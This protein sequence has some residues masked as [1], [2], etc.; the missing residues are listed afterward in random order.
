MRITK[1]NI[2][3][4][5]SKFRKEAEKVVCRNEVYDSSN[6]SPGKLTELLHELQVYQVE[7]EMQNEE[8]RISQV[9]LEK[10]RLK[11]KNLFNSAPAGFFVLDA[12]GIVQELNEKGLLML[13]ANKSEIINRRIQN[14]ISKD[15][16]EKFVCFFKRI[17]DF[18][19]NQSGEFKMVTANGRNFYTQMEGRAVT[20]EISQSAAFYFTIIDVTEKKIAE[21]KQN[22]TRKRLELALYASSSGTWNVY[23]KTGKVLLDQHS[24]SI[25]RLKEG[26]LIGNYYSFLNIIHPDDRDEVDKNIHAAIATETEL[27]VTFRLSN[28]GSKVYYIEAMGQ[29]IKEPNG[30]NDFAGLLTD[31]TEKKTLEHVALKLKFNE[32]NRI[33]KTILETQENERRRI[34]NDLHHSV[35]Q[36]LYVTKLKFEESMHGNNVS[37]AFLATSILIDEAI[38]EVRNIS[39]QLS[40]S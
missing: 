9:E 7:V 21:N 23:L 36:L 18:N 24:K 4:D 35:G 32:Q 26:G 3:E 37:P 1:K 25:L 19:V 22:E 10:E 15:D 2:K 12:Y 34:S 40:P 16:N 8:L 38:K 27:N 17:K 39:F 13:E 11:F 33:I 6:L 29:V 5:E 14:Y 20:D 31:I 28:T 30:E